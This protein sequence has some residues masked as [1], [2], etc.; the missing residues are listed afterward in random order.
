MWIQEMFTDRLQINIYKVETD[1]TIIWIQ[2]ITF[3]LAA[4]YKK[5]LY[6]QCDSVCLHSVYSQSVCGTHPIYIRVPLPFRYSFCGSDLTVRP[7][8]KG[9]Q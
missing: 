6:L 3:L 2:S 4:S 9:G 8:P 5:I 7:V 1:T